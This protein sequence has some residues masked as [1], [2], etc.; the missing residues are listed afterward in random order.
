MF[1]NKNDLKYINKEKNEYMKKSNIVSLL[2]TVP[3]AMGTLTACNSD[4]SD[5]AEEAKEV[6]TSTTTSSEEGNSGKETETSTSTE[7]EIKLGEQKEPDFVDEFGA[8][9]LSSDNLKD[10]VV[11]VD[12]VFDFAC[13]AC[14]LVDTMLK[15]KLKE[16]VENGEITLHLNP[17][18]FLDD[19]TKNDYSSRAASAFLTVAEESPEKAFEFMSMLYSNEYFNPDG[20]SNKEVGEDY[21]IDIAKE[22]GVSSNTQEAIKENHYYEW[23]K[24]FTEKAAVDTTLYSEQETLSTPRIRFGRDTDKPGTAKLSGSAEEDYLMYLDMYKNPEKTFK[25]RGE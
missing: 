2:I 11:R 1:Y 5:I 15:D 3:L 10:D 14:Q 16:Q 4:N 12:M 21:F 18:S 20:K 25:L 22:I 17:I 23:V 9:E 8:V 13:P 7:S 19:A 6:A 24:R